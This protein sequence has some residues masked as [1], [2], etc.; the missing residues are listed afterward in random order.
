[1]AN[2][3]ADLL[4]KLH[5]LNITLGG[6]TVALCCH[7]YFFSGRRPPLYIAL[8][9]LIAGPLEDLLQEYCC[10]H[11]HLRPR[12]RRQC[13]ALVDKLTSLAFLLLLLLAAKV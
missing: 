5:L 1:M 13:V 4:A 12:Q 7:D 6:M 2:S 3:A 8:A 9:I 10:R 11:P